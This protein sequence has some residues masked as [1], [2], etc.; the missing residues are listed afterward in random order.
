M[1]IKL[2]WPNLWKASP[3]FVAK[4]QQIHEKYIARRKKL[5][6]AGAKG[7]TIK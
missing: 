4:I 2:R 6:T 7:D 1:K 5:L 3:E